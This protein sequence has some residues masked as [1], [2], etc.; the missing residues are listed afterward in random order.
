MI[1]PMALCTGEPA[2][3]PAGLRG[4]RTW[5]INYRGELRS[6]LVRHT[7]QL[8]GEQAVCHRTELLDVSRITKGVGLAF[9]HG[10]SCPH[11][12][13]GCGIYG[14]Y[15]PDDT[16]LAQAAV[17]GAVEASGRILMGT[18]GFRAER[19]RVLAV[20]TEGLPDDVTAQLSER[21]TWQ[22]IAVF[23]DR[24][25][26]VEA[27]PPDDLTGLVDHVCDGMCSS[28]AAVDLA[29]AFQALAAAAIVQRAATT[30]TTTAMY[31]IDP[32]DSPDPP[33]RWKRLAAVIACTFMLL[34]SVSSSAWHLWV[35]TVAPALDWP[36]LAV[37]LLQAG[38]A[39]LWG[40]WLQQ[41]WRWGR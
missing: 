17:F 27:F 18:H 36:A 10:G 29:R 11:P 1:S 26:L 8:S 6:T 25:Q 7:W 5:R 20:S 14:W 31:V 21:A 19:A 12:P 4:Y 3:I 41:A 22:G 37:A 33:P 16:R 35:W 9:D 39:V 28:P 13:C 40:R 34:A 30:A 23:G 38:L 2:L 32:D 15:D 24:A